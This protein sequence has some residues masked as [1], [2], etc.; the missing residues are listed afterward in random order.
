M[1]LANIERI[2]HAVFSNERPLLNG[3]LSLNFPPAHD[4]SA[5]RGNDG[6]DRHVI[7]Q[8]P[9]EKPLQQKP[10]EQAPVFVFLQ[11]K[12]NKRREKIYE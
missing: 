3:C 8:L 1:F 12:G 4:R 2:T 6:L 10:D 11:Q 9:I 7:H 5:N